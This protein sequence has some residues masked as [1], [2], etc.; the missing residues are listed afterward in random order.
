MSYQSKYLVSNDG[1]NVIDLPYNGKNKTQKYYPKNSDMKNGYGQVKYMG[2]PISYISPIK[3]I[4]FNNPDKVYD[5]LVMKG[6]DVQNT[7]GDVYEKAKIYV[8]RTQQ[9]GVI[10][11]VKYAHPDLGV[12]SEAIG[13]SSADSS[14]SYGETPNG[15]KKANNT[16]KEDS[17]ENSNNESEN[18]IK[19]LVSKYSNEQ[20]KTFAI[21]AL[22]IFVIVL[23]YK[24]Q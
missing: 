11:L 14:S 2:K 6:I 18:V 9:Q 7:I 8:K 12:I 15:D 23:L 19:K 3:Y 17:K 20:L 10:E 21:V 4:V 22:V 24:R 5:F 13:C 16:K 1:I